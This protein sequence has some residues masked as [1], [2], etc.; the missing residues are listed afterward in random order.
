MA[1]MGKQECGSDDSRIYYPVW[2]GETPLSSVENCEVLVSKPKPDTGHPGNRFDI[3][4]FGLR[5]IGG[6][7]QKLYPG[8]THVRSKLTVDFVP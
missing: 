5:K 3:V 4:S 8:Y 7:A 6:F 2:F 1:V